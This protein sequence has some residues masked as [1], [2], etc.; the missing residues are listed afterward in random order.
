[1]SSTTLSNNENCSHSHIEL[2]ED[3]SLHR[4]ILDEYSEKIIHARNS[5]QNPPAFPEDLITPVLDNT[6]HDSAEAVINNWI[7]KVY[8]LTHIDRRKPFNDS[9]NPDDPLGLNTQ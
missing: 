7:G 8:Q 1:M 3:Q 2:Q 6:W 5:N 9:V 4:A